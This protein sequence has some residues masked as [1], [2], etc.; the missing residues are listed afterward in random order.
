[1]NIEEDQ[2]L[3]KW[4]L[5]IQTN[6]CFRL[7]NTNFVKNNQYNRNS[8]LKI[9]M[10]PL[11]NQYSDEHDTGILP[12][13]KT[14]EESKDGFK[15]EEKPNNVEEILESED[16]SKETLHEIPEDK[17]SDLEKNTYD[18]EY[19]EYSDEDREILSESENE[20]YEEKNIVVD[21]RFL[22]G[23]ESIQGCQEKERFFSKETYPESFLFVSE[24]TADVPT[25]S[26]NSDQEYL[27]KYNENSE[28]ECA[29]EQKTETESKNGEESEREENM[30]ENIEKKGGN[31]E[32][33]TSFDGNDEKQKHSPEQQNDAKDT[34]T[35]EDTRRLD[36]LT[37]YISSPA[38]NG[39]N[40]VNHL[41][42]QEKEDI[43]EHQTEQ[44][45]QQMCDKEKDDFYHQT[46]SETE[47]V[48]ESCLENISSAVI[49]PSVAAKTALHVKRL[50]KK[51]KKPGKKKSKKHSSGFTGSSSQQGSKESSSENVSSEEE[52]EPES[53]SFT[54]KEGINS[55]YSSSEEVYKKKMSSSEGVSENSF[56]SSSEDDPENSFSSSEDDPENSYSSSSE[57]DTANSYSSSSEEGSASF[58]SSSE[59]GSASFSSSSE[60]GSAS[61]SSSSE[62]GYTR[63]KSLCSGEGSESSGSDF[64]KPQRQKSVH[65]LEKTK[66]HLTRNKKKPKKKNRNFR[67]SPE[68]KKWNTM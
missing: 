25:E 19:G 11:Q 36:T 8:L 53:C 47:K 58:S 17:T 12:D 15:N 39:Y 7:I 22:L 1:M 38:S 60:E 42:T 10:N 68:K 49:I 6:I 63:K 64:T 26:T 28:I 57:D 45:D 67:N 32:Q 20:I 30:Y 18:T 41:Q 40:D 44:L 52:N 5:I 24:N 50:T 33:F 34:K 29:N 21:S 35:T 43:N 48:V 14:H 4:I 61:F 23:E 16:V 3:E 27:T 13:E 62:E 66:Q 37:G 55:L 51:N 46:V 31:L 54:A 9:I 65:S 59:E 2:E 56:S